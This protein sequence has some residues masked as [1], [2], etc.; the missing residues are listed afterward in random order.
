MRCLISAFTTSTHLYGAE[1]KTLKQLEAGRDV[2]RLLGGAERPDGVGQV[3]LG[4][5]FAVKLKGAWS[6]GSSFRIFQLKCIDHH[7]RLSDSDEVAIAK[8][9][10]TA[11]LVRLDELKGRGSRLSDVLFESQPAFPK[12]VQRLRST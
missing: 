6:L 4:L 11:H 5:W 1:E 8:S 10:I 9:S 12:Q 3:L 7:R 2:A